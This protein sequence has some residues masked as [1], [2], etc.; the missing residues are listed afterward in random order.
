MNFLSLFARNLT[1]GP[2][3]DPFP[4][5]PAPTA[6]RFRGKIAFD[7]TTCEACRKCER[8]CPTGAI[9]FERTPEGMTFDC[10][11][12]T[13]VFCGNCVFQCNTGAIVQTDDWH[14]AHRQS[15]KYLQV[16][17]G[18]IP[19]ITCSKCGG[20]GLDSAPAVARAKPPLTPE[21]VQE[22]RSLC[23]KCRAKYLKERKE[24]A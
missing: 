15:D 21:E 20:K 24:R 7:A 4:F 18:L 11:H 16:E 17:H 22:L 13:C 9:R 23:P 2:Y 19:A 6:P 5:A 8:A 14:L 1:Q 12:N 10:W 3:T